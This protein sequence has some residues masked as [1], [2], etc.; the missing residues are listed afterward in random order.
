MNTFKRK[1][2]TCAVLAGLGAVAT[3]AEAVVRNP[4]NTAMVLVYPYYTVQSAGG[5]RFNTDVSITNTTSRAKVVKGRFP[6]GKTSAEDLDFNVYLPPN[7]MRVRGGR[8]A[9]T[10]LTPPGRS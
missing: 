10:A 4:D 3:S 8:P 6:Q 7:H 5:N 2:L 9:R 1:A